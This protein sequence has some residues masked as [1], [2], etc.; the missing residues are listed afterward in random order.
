M[1][2]QILNGWR[3]SGVNDVNEQ[4]D[5]WIRRRGGYEKDIFSILGLAELDGEPASVWREKVIV[6][7][8]LLRVLARMS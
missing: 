6:G 8:I 3:E 5:L 1:S 4:K 7:V 2:K